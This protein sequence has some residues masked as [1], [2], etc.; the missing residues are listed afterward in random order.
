MTVQVRSFYAS[1]GQD[2]LVYFRL[3]G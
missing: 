1:L 2:I 3:S